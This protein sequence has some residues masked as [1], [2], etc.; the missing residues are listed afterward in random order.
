MEDMVLWYKN[1]CMGISDDAYSSLRL[2]QSH[3]ILAANSTHPFLGAKH[4]Q[5]IPVDA[6][7]FRSHARDQLPATDLLHDVGAGGI[8]CGN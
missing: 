2:R 7:E 4:P 8:R 1:T 5:F 6:P 3:A